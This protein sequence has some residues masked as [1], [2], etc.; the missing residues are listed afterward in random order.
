MTDFLRQLGTKG[1][2]LLATAIIGIFIVALGAL[3][4]KTS[5]RNESP[6]AAQQSLAGGYE[7]EWLPGA[8]DAESATYYEVAFRNGD[9]PGWSGLAERGK[10]VPISDSH[11]RASDPI[12]GV[13]AVVV[14]SGAQIGERFYVGEAVFR[15]FVKDQGCQAFPWVR[16][17]GEYKAA[18]KD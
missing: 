9:V 17:H 8:V 4:S 14:E 13:V 11:I 3:F 18:P 2:S 10:V 12:G 5:S 16:T 1:R 15:C 6:E 7:V